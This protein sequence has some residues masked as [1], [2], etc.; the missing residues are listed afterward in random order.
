MELGTP[1][2]FAVFRRDNW[3]GHRMNHA[4]QHQTRNDLCRWSNGTDSGRD[5]YVG[6]EYN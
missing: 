5:D 3:T 1:D 2:N 6:I 4:T